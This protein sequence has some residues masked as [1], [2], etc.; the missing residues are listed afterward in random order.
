MVLSGLFPPWFLG[1]IMLHE[2]PQRMHCGGL[3]TEHVP[4]VFLLIFTTV[5]QSTAGQGIVTT[6]SCGVPVLTLGLTSIFFG[7]RFEKISFLARLFSVYSLSIGAFS[8]SLVRC[9]GLGIISCAKGR[10]TGLMRQYPCCPFKATINWRDCCSRRIRWNIIHY[11]GFKTT[12]FKYIGVQFSRF[13]HPRL[14]NVYFGYKAD[15]ISHFSL[16]FC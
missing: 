9:L 3:H 15:A 11:T 8:P 5:A 6:Y 2:M 14:K 16:L 10:P 12:G 4:S 7:F 13:K 1:Q